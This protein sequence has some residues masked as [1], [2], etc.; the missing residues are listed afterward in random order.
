M[1]LLK[2]GYTSTP[3]WSWS[4][5]L[6]KPWHCTGPLHWCRLYTVHCFFK[7]SVSTKQLKLIPLTLKPW[8]SEGVKNT[9]MSISGQEV[10]RCQVLPCQRLIHFVKMATAGRS[11]KFFHNVQPTSSVM[12]ISGTKHYINL[13]FLK[14]ADQGKFRVFS[15]ST[16]V[17]YSLVN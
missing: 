9:L 5:T 13:I 14:G 1:V 3:Y 8:W 11:G 7:Y 10:L 15:W 16:V 6:A 17:I 4:F 12:N 2:I